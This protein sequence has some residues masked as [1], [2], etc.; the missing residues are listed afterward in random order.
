[1]K[2]IAAAIDVG[3]NSVLYLIVEIKDGQIARIIEEGESIT[4]LGYDTHTSAKLKKSPMLK[5][6][7]AIASFYQRCQLLDAEEIYITATSAV[8]DAKNNQVF[9]DKIRRKTGSKLMLLSGDKEAEVS[10]IGACSKLPVQTK[11]LTVI[12]V[13]GGSTEIIKG[14]IN[15]IDVKKSV[16]IGCVRLTEMFIAHNPPTAAEVNTLQDYVKN[17]IVWAG[18]NGKI[19]DEILIGVGGTITTLAMVDLKLASYDS[20][21]L[22]GHSL[23]LKRITKL[24]QQLQQLSKA[25]RARVPGISPGRVDIIVAGA[26]IFECAMTVYNFT[27]IVVST[28]GLRHGILLQKVADKSDS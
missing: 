8:R 11:Y 22:Q 14:R 13:G 9:I 6:V 1:M 27:E 28:R 10:F 20:R 18:I 17:E 12:D 25:E 21:Q 15:Q 24:R 26:T 3:T 7:R 23:S 19:N 4:R 2:K 16:D 5:T